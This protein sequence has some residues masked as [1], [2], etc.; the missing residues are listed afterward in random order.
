MTL[1]QELVQQQNKLPG[2]RCDILSA[3]FRKIR[4][5]M[6]ILF[7]IEYGTVSRKRYA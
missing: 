7:W 5:D 4:M 3:G 2:R 6:G 1:L